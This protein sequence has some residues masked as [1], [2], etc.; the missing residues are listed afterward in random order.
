VASIALQQPQGPELTRVGE[1]GFP[2]PHRRPVHRRSSLCVWR[3]L[4]G[5][6]PLLWGGMASVSLL[7]WTWPGGTLIAV[8]ASSLMALFPAVECHHLIAKLALREWAT[9]CYFASWTSRKAMCQLFNLLIWS[10]NSW[11]NH[12]GF[13]LLD[14]FTL[15]SSGKQRY[16][17]QVQRMVPLY[18]FW[19][20]VPLY[21]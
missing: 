3:W 18:C 21:C 17:D 11:F 2:P 4:E 5:S 20:M 1:I 12:T 13:Q 16:A 14:C 15:F 7:V 8:P 9:E 19:D 6:Y 10:S